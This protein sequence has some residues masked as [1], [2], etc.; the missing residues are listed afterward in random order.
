[1]STGGRRRDGDPGAATALCGQERRMGLSSLKCTA[2]RRGEP[3]ASEDEIREYLK[4]LGEWELLAGKSPPRIA[5]TFRFAAFADAL[6]FTTQ[7]GSLAESE[8]HHPEMVIAWGRVTV[9]WWTHAIGGLHRND[10][11]MAAKTDELYR[12]RPSG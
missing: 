3:P 8:G 11:V 4:Q 6:L 9:S 1:L 7:V 10:F 12:S 5:R 2:C